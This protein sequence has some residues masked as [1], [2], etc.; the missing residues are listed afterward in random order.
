LVPYARTRKGKTTTSKNAKKQEGIECENEQMEITQLTYGIN[1]SEKWSKI[2]DFS[3]PQGPE[4]LI[5][6]TLS[7]L[8]PESVLQP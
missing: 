4:I 5:S 7:D 2:F 8:A 6:T 3:S 1:K